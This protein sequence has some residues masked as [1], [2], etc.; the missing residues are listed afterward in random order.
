MPAAHRRAPSSG[1]NASKAGA[2]CSDDAAQGAGQT[3][4]ERNAVAPLETLIRH[5]DTL[6]RVRW[7]LGQPQGVIWVTGPSGSGKTTIL[8][9]SLAEINSPDLNIS[10]VEDPI[11]FEFP[12]ITQLQVQNDIGLTISRLVRTLF[13]QDPDVIMIGEIRDDETAKLALEAAVT[14]H[15]VLTLM[16]ANDAVSAFQRLTET[17]IDAPT[18]RSHRSA[19]MPQNLCRMQS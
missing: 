14:G 2:A 15:L 9:S 1:K 7:M 19:A 5:E 3:R 11:E 10:T 13:K 12:G 18:Y 17:G 8:Y 6:K 16:H 4:H